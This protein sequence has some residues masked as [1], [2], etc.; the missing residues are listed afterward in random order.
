MTMTNSE[1]F[2]ERG[3]MVTARGALEKRDRG[4]RRRVF[5]RSGRAAGPP[6]KVRTW[7][8]GPAARPLRAREKRASAR[9][10]PSDFLDVLAAAREARTLGVVEVHLVPRHAVR[11]VARRAAQHPDRQR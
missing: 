5:Q 6:V 4:E 3:R 1:P 9:G 11:R 10:A 7:T 8:G 2:M